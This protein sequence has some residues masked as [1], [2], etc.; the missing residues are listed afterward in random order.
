MSHPG[1]LLAGG[2]VSV[3]L[4]GYSQ[5]SPGSSG[6]GQGW[7]GRRLGQ[8][9]GRTSVASFKPFGF[10][11]VMTVCILR[12]TGRGTYGTRAPYNDTTIVAINCSLAYNYCDHTIALLLG[13]RYYLLR[14][15]IYSAIFTHVLAP[16]QGLAACK[17][18][19]SC[20]HLALFLGR[21]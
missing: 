10:L 1:V 8:Q 20:L 18:Y 9:I 14:L 6:Y 11:S 15:H 4:S 17:H 13:R 2:Y 21:P 3:L 12:P 5:L 7:I 19:L 16:W